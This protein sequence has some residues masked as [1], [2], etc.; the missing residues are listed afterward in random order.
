MKPT[1][2]NIAK[3]C[4][5]SLGTVDRALNGRQGI[6]EKTK[7]RIL[8]VAKDIEY[9]PDY[10]ARSLVIGRTMTIGVVLFDLYNRAFAQLMNAIELKA[11]ARGY[12][13][14]VTFTQKKKEAEKQ[15]IEDLINR[16]VDGIILFSVN[17]GE[18]LNKYK[19]YD[20]PIITIFNYISDE[21]EYIGINERQAMKE[22]VRYVIR[23]DYESFIY[24]SPALAW[25]GKRNIYTQR[26]R[27][28]GFKEALAES[29]I[30]ENKP[31]VIKQK[32]YIRYLE[33]MLSDIHPKTAII[34]SAD[35]YALEVMLHLQEK[36]WS[37]P[38]DIGLMGFDDIDML[39]FVKPKLSTVNYP[40]EQIGILAVDSLIQKIEEGEFQKNAF[41]KHVIVEGESI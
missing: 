19:K 37:I 1:I 17:E 36:G 18:E 8:Q 23:K 35:H 15:C 3:I 6:S 33:P 7:Q 11:R 32:E 24:I 25:E 26:E 14:Y 16:K 30:G 20:I 39:K 9:R 41:L 12:F 34:C 21:W 13:V 31:T 29:A 38:K 5:V 40:I 4:G 22:A 2:K 27:Y 28:E 10:R